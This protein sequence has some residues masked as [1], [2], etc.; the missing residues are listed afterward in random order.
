MKSGN[1]ILVL[2]VTAVA[3]CIITIIIGRGVGEYRLINS[4]L[5]SLVIVG[6]MLVIIPPIEINENA[7][8]YTFLLYVSHVIW[9]MPIIKIVHKLGLKNTCFELALDTMVVLIVVT[10]VFYVLKKLP[11]I[12]RIMLGNR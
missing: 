4:Q 7:S 6:C 8:G 11:K 3:Y 10:V 5:V 12:K 1:K 2:I 9:A